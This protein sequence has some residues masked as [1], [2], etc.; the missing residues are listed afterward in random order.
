MS[1]R[2]LAVNGYEWYENKKTSQTVA[3]NLRKNNIK[4]HQNFTCYKKHGGSGLTS[5]PTQH[6]K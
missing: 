4:P 5:R 3:V 1:G 6:P 2:V